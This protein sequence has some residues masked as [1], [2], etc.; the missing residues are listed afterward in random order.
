MSRHGIA[1]KVPPPPRPFLGPS[2]FLEK[3]WRRRERYPDTWDRGQCPAP[4]KPPPG[5]SANIDFHEPSLS[6]TQ[7]ITRCRCMLNWYGIRGVPTSTLHAMRARVDELLLGAW[8]RVIGSRQLDFR[9]LGTLYHYTTIDGLRGILSSG[10][11]R[12]FDTS[13][14]EDEIPY[15]D[16]QIFK[17]LEHTVHATTDDQHQRVLLCSVDLLRNPRL[18]VRSFASSLC[19][20]SENPALWQRFGDQGRG[21]AIGFGTNEAIGGF[22]DDTDLLWAGAV[23]M[24]YDETEQVACM[25]ALADAAAAALASRPLIIPEVIASCLSA[26][27]SSFRVVL[28]HPKYAEEKEWRLSVSYFAEGELPIRHAAGAEHDHIEVFRNPFGQI[29][30]PVQEIIVGPLFQAPPS[31]DEMRSWLQDTGLDP[32]VV[33]VSQSLVAPSLLKSTLNQG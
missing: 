5:R 9:R 23:Q 17:W 14:Y 18:A 25:N 4:S 16:D 30:V 29:P 7:R 3:W 19:E 24:L 11:L 15:R 28:K 13:R 12:A 6:H 26:F 1:G 31:A 10:C 27:L 32:N 21:V 20:S 2:L 8:D 33:Q 22:T